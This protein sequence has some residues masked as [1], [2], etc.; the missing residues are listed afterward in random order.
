M[1]NSGWSS[2]DPSSAVEESNTDSEGKG[3]SGLMSHKYLERV[4][5]YKNLINHTQWLIGNKAICS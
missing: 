5:E 4:G 1:I 2:K 3:E